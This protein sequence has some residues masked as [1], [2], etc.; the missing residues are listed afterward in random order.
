MENINQVA[1][2]IFAAFTMGLAIKSYFEFNNQ[3]IHHDLKTNWAWSL[4]FLVLSNIGYAI[5]AMGF[6]VFLFFGYDDLV[7][8]QPSVYLYLIISCISILY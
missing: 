8:A 6:H 3:I 7:Q 5:G 1:Y 4:L 2:L